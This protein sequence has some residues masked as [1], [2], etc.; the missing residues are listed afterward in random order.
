MAR[1][2]VID[3]AA[4]HHLETRAVG[5][6]VTICLPHQPRP[7]IPILIIRIVPKVCAIECWGNGPCAMAVA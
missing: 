7:I 3:V 6:Q 1:R 4:S 5:R 2:V